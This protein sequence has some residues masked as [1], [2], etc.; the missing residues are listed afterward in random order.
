[1]KELSG[2]FIFPQVFE[3]IILILKI[4]KL[5]RNLF[6]IWDAIELKQM[7]GGQKLKF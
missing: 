4:Y 7:F 5:K 1:V 2:Y 6:K 3:I